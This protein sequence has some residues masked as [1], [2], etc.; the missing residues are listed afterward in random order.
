MQM[1]QQVP[2]QVQS[3]IASTVLAP[4]AMASSISLEATLLQ[5][6]TTILKNH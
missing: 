2:A 3:M 6:H 1:P 5:R 4:S